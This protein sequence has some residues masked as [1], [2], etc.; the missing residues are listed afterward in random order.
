MNRFT[1]FSI[2]ALFVVASCFQSQSSA[3]V[4]LGSFENLPA[5]QD[6]P[7]QAVIAAIEAATGEKYTGLQRLYKNDFNEGTGQGDDA[8][9]RFSTNYTVNN[10]GDATGGAIFQ[11]EIPVMIDGEI[12]T[13]LFYTAKIDGPNAG[14]NLY[15][16]G[17]D[18]AFDWGFFKDI[19]NGLVYSYTN[20]QGVVQT[21]SWAEPTTPV[22][23]T[24][25][26]FGVSHVSVFGA[27]DS[28]G[29]PTSPPVTVPEPASL[30]IF[31]FGAFG[32][33]LAQLRRRRRAASTSL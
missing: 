32:L 16:W 31:G 33:G 24:L 25:V 6:D 5:G 9:D 17:V 12:F 18:N 2:A 28:S 20:N 19:D 22:V 11:E 21:N 10:E 26:N 29:P 4:L 23:G 8:N 27:V 1:C 30:A 14:F 15:R 3:G 13:P 7:I